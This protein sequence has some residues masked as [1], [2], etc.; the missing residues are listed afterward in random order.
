[1]IDVYRFISINLWRRGYFIRRVFFILA[2][3]MP[4][5]IRSGA[6]LCAI[7]AYSVHWRLFHTPHFHFAVSKFDGIRSGAKGCRWRMQ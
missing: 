5:G 6:R 1:M 7:G 3:P 4:D 2:V